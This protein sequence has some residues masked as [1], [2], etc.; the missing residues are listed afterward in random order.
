M[1]RTI[2]QKMSPD[3]IHQSTPLIHQC[4]PQTEATIGNIDTPRACQAI[5]NQL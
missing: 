5:I 1:I 3:R 4:H 2:T